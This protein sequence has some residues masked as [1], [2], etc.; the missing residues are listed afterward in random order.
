MV[1]HQELRFWGDAGE[2]V[3]LEVSGACETLK[4]GW[5]GE[6]PSKSKSCGGHH[7]KQWFAAGCRGKT[8]KYGMSSREDDK[9]QRG[10]RIVV[11]N[12]GAPGKSK[13]CGE[14]PKECVGLAIKA[15]QN[16]RRRDGGGSDR[17]V[18]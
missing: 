15:Q 3:C 6:T 17:A 1:R 18:R 5:C 13:I 14:I 2:D 4:T 9:V 12:G 7:I 16:D 10:A 11:Q 8:T